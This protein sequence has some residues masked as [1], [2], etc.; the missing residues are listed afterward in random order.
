MLEPTAKL[1]PATLHPSVQA[2]IEEFKD[3][4]SQDLPPGLPPKWG[5]EHQIDLIP[6]D[7]L[8]NKPAYRC[9]PT[10]TKE[11]Q[12]QVQELIDRGYVRESISP[13]SVPALLVPKKD[14]SW[15]MCTDSR[16]INNITIKY[17]YPIPRLDDMLDKLHGSKIFSKIN[18][19]SGYH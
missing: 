17:R 19:R 10:K 14:G 7:P 8:T 1:D 11:L 12:R 18:L 3:V 4:F 15:R 16:A 6:G 9:N 5:I 13:C 2:F